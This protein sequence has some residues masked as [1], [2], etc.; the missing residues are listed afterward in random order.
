MDGNLHRVPVEGG[1]SGARDGAYKGYLDGHPAGFIQNFKTGFKSNWKATGQRLDSSQIAKIEAEA[2][3]KKQ[4]RERE[5]Q[6][7]YAAK[8]E[9][10]ASELSLLPEAPA[11]HPYLKNKGLDTAGHSFGAKIDAQGNLVVPIEDKDG[12]IWSA[13]RIGA[14]GFKGYE[15]KARLSG[16]CQVIGGKN[17]LAAQDAHEPVLISTGFATSASI[18][19]ATGKP[20]VVAFQ[21]S[22][23]LDVAQ[24]FKRAFPERTI[25]ILGDDDRHLPYRTPPLPNSGKDKATAAAKAVGGRAIFPRFTSDEKGRKFTDFSD[26]QRVRGLATVQRQI[27]RS[28]GF[29]RGKV[30]ARNQ[31]EAMLEKRKERK[32]ER[33]EKTNKLERS[34]PQRTI[35]RGR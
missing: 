35:E 29:S 24:E 22:N 4:A 34:I 6:A 7:V 21:D 33:E 25:A 23:L 28:L 5:R 27:Q 2:E 15:E 17:A 20:V 14:N 10:V 11:D 3:V 13:Q 8:A 31:R 26:L 32:N 9:M 12:K 30:N 16:C 1:K 19:L 18:H